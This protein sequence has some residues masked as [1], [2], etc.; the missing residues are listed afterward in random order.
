MKSAQ[1]EQRNPKPYGIRL[2]SRDQERLEELLA[3]LEANGD[4][5]EKSASDAMRW[6]LDIKEV[7]DIVEGRTLARG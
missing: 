1:K 5:S 7:R 4:G 2:Y 3:Y 6:L